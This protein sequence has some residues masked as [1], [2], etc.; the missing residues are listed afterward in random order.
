[1]STIRA[2]LPDTANDF[3][4]YYVGLARCYITPY[5]NNQFEA[6][7]LIS[8]PRIMI[9]ALSSASNLEALKEHGVTHILCI[10]NGGIPF[11]PDAFE[12]KIIHTNDDPWVDVCTYFNETSAYIND[13]LTSST[14]NK[15]F[16]HCQ[17]GESRSVTI[18]AAYL[19][20][21]INK[22]NR[23][24]KEDLSA[25]VSSVISSIQEVRSNARPNKGFIDCLTKYI[26]MINEHDEYDTNQ[27]S[28]I[29]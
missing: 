3:I 4:M 21:M 24:K 16:V 18:V 17:C 1:M 5:I 8:E 15:I 13:T 23:I 12:Y 29:K 10:M 28:N 7:T 11:F 22:N 19:L 9:G 25:T 6:S 20:Y 14:N 26:Y 2:N 27:I